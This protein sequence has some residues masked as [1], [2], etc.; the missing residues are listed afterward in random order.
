MLRLVLDG[1]D[2]E[3]DLEVQFKAH[4]SRGV[5]LLYQRLKKLEDLAGL[6]TEAQRRVSMQSLGRATIDG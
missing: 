4:L 3:A 5:L 2:P 1:L 6:V